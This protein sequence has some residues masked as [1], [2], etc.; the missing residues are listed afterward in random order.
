[1]KEHCTSFWTA[2]GPLF[3]DFSCFLKTIYC[4]CGEQDATVEH[5]LCA[6]R[7]TQECYNVLRTEAAMVPARW[8]GQWTSIFRNFFVLMTL[9]ITCRMMIGST[10]FRDLLQPVLTSFA[11]FSYFQNC[12]LDTRGKKQEGTSGR[13]VLIFP[14]TVFKH[15]NNTIC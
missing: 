14:I 11:S 5:A 10:K 8:C 6:C 9:M 13:C 7:C 12:F 1:M 4:K 15:Q 2:C 3:K